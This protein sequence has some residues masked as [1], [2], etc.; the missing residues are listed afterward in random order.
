MP[1]P[2]PADTSLVNRWQLQD[3]VGTVCLGG[4]AAAL[5]VFSGI[6]PARSGSS[7]KCCYVRS[8]LLCGNVSFGWRVARRG[9]HNNASPD[10]FRKYCNRFGLWPWLTTEPSNKRITQPEGPPA[11]CCVHSSAQCTVLLSSGPA[12]ELIIRVMYASHISGNFSCHYCGVITA[13]PDYT[14]AEMKGA[15]YDRRS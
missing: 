2:R 11:A 12:D 4:R 8:A 1:P 7:F 14:P 13:Q 15:R 9:W 5:Q 10:L 3:A 6:W